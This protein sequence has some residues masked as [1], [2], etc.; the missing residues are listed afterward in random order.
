[1]FATRTSKAGLAAG[2]V[3]KTMIGPITGRNLFST[4][5]PTYKFR[6]TGTAVIAL[7]GTND[8]ALSSPDPN[9][10]SPDQ[11]PADGATWTEIAASAS[12]TSGTFDDDYRFLRL[13]IKTPGDGDILEAWAYWN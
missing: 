13:I 1:M 3:L 7:E 11:E 5:D 4:T 9:P 10:F 2:T 8:A 6:Q 12:N